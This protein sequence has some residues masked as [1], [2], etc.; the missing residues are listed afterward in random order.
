MCIALSFSDD[1]WYIVC[2][3]IYTSSCVLD[4]VCETNMYGDSC[5]F[6]QSWNLVHMYPYAHLHVFPSVVPGGL[7]P[8]LQERRGR[9]V[10]R[11]VRI[12]GEPLPLHCRL[13]FLFPFLFVVVIS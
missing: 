9:H 6:F 4:N 12:A 7:P 8:I 13:V 2:T 3:S 1:G 10:Y 5:T 11:D